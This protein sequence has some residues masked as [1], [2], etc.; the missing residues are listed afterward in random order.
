MPVSYGLVELFLLM[1]LLLFAALLLGSAAA[2]QDLSAFTQ[3]AQRCSASGS[4]PACR[5]ALE[6][7]HTLKNWAESRKLWRCYTA[8]LAAEAA[9]IA[10]SFPDA[11]QPEGSGAWQE[12]RAMC[13]R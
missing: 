13:G 12:M 2:A 10:A 8:V 1:R 11:Q 3:Q 4:A 5:A 7:S 6:Q 9:M